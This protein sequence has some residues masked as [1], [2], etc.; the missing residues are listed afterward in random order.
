MEYTLSKNTKHKLSPSIVALIGTLIIMLGG[1]LITYNYVES[2]KIVAYDYVSTEFFESKKETPPK[3]K[4]KV[5]EEAKEEEVQPVETPQEQVTND[6]IGYLQ[7]PK[8][9]L[10]KGFLDQKSTENNVEKNIYVVGGSSYPDV[11]KGNL[12]IAAHSGT[13]WKAF[14]NDLYKLTNGDIAVITYKNKKYTYRV[15]NIYKQPKTGRIAIYRNYEKTTLTL[16]T[17]T[18]HDLTT[19]TVY[20]A[21]LVNVE[22]E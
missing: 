13:G 10:N 22:S 20:I 12:I 3:V 15:T 7:I 17:C 14:F 16:V 19:Q 18:N 2:K 5:K 4:E 21:E 8:I 11:K 1:Y 9:N 6:Y